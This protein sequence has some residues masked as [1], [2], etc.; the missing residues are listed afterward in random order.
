MRRAV[1]VHRLDAPAVRIRGIGRVG[2]RPP[3]VAEREARP[4][5]EVAIGRRAARREVA[6]GELG[7]CLVA[8][9]RSGSRHALVERGVG[10]LLPGIGAAD[11]DALELSEH[12]QVRESEPGERHVA[13]L[14]GR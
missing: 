8:R 9:L 4:R 11:R 5:R 3:G 13:G 1:D 12:E 2:E 6:G 10:A 7:E 14:E